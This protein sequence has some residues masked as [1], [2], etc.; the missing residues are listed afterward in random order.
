[1]R[2]LIL[3]ADPLV[4][5][6]LAE[7]VRRRRPDME[8]HT[9]SSLHA[10][11]KRL[12]QADYEAII[13]DGR[14]PDA[15]GVAAL[16]V[17][18]QRYPDTP[19]ML[20]SVELGQDLMAYATLSGVYHV[21][22]KPIEHNVLIVLLNRVIEQRQLGRQIRQLTAKAKRHTT[23]ARKAVAYARLLLESKD[24][25]LSR[26]Q[27]A[28]LKSEEERQRLT[29]LMDR[30][31]HGIMAFDRSW[32]IVCLNESVPQIFRLKS[33]E[34]LLGK[35]VWAECAPL[36]D[37]DFERECR[38]AVRDEVAVQFQSRF[39]G[40]DHRHDVHA[41]PHDD[42]LSVFMSSPAGEQPSAVG[43]RPMSIDAEDRGL[44]SRG[45]EIGSLRTDR[46]TADAERNSAW[47]GL[48][49]QVHTAREAERSRIARDLDDDLG[50]LLIALKTDLAWLDA[51]LTH[52]QLPALLKVRFMT[53]LV[54]RIT[55]TVRRICSEL[56]PAILDDLGLPAAM[57]WQATTFEQRTGLRCIVSIQDVGP[58]DAEPA[59]GLFRIFQELL[60][61]TARQAGATVVWI[62]LK[63]AAG[64]LML[65]VHDN[66][67][68]LTDDMG[69]HAPTLLTLRERTTLLRGEV[70]VNGMPGQGTSVS[71]KIPT[72]YRNTSVL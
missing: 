25:L 48:S 17:L 10:G 50:Q 43:R 71:V 6:A 33:R 72:A 23:R 39:P 36:T 22:H 34:E 53:H 69:F 66:G 24:G 62:T 2:I 32:R 54:N 42:G 19:I 11:L 16:S 70:S 46:E 51:R 41:V 64:W 56:R 3:D 4:L 60:A 29:K 21:L 61:N 59:T 7:T 38:R 26:R 18:R 30:S 13:C 35:E 68:G 65:E 1:M 8:A 67:R 40:E 12:A 52:D 9:A 47:R 58:I 28:L 63:E 44:G 49:E 14:L 31:R 57:Q 45:D 37:S 55:D 20:M 15:P 5:S 27:D